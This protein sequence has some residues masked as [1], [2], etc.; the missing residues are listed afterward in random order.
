M[1]KDRDRIEL[2]CIG[3]PHDGEWITI[4][5]GCREMLAPGGRYVRTRTRKRRRWK[6]R[7]WVEVLQ[8]SLY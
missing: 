6:G 2:L 3:G 7:E 4:A 1:R 8:W 5:A